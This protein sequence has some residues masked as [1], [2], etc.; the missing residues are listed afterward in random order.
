MLHHLAV[1]V[2]VEDVDAG[3]LLVTGPGLEAVQDDA[4]ALGESPLE[5]DPLAG[6]ADCH[7]LE[8]VLEGLLAVPD[9]RIVLDVVVARV[10]RDG[11]CGP[12]LVEH[13]VVEGRDVGLVAV[14]VAAHG[15]S[16]ASSQQR[17]R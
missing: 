3:V 13:E 9:V 16:N 6:I 2:E 12:A 17:F 15:H 4:V 1:V 5:L 14:R 7:P 8:V 10:L 11:F